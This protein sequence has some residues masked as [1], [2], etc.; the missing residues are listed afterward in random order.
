M[1]TD[2]TS[3]AHTETRKHRSTD[4]LWFFQNHFSGFC[5]SVIQRDALIN[6]AFKKPLADFTFD[7]QSIHSAICHCDI[8]FIAVP[9]ILLACQPVGLLA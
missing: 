8:P 1:Y 6:Y 9:R 7:H 3:K 2:G 4:G 5:V